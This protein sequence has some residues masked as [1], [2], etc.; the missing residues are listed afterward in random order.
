MNKTKKTIMKGAVI[1]GIIILP[2]IYSITYLKG[3]WDPYNNLGDMKV[4]IVNN[5]KCDSNCKSDILIDKLKDSDSFNFIVKDSK[6]AEEGLHDK[7]YYAVITIPSDFTSSFENADK[8]DRSSATITYRPNNKTNYIASQL[9]NNALLQVEMKLDSEVSKEVVGGLSTK[10]EEIPSLTDRLS[11]GFSNLANGTSLLDNGVS[12]L[13]EG[14]S[15]LN[16]NY[17][18]FDNG[19]NDLNNVIKESTDGINTINDKSGQIREGINT[20]SQ[21]MNTLREGTEELSNNYQHIAY[22]NIAVYSDSIDDVGIKK[23]YEY[24]L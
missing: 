16:S 24:K 12:T 21:S 3:F 2:L 17:R 22:D 7:K 5:D 8:K 20:I 6:T 4:A 11:N 10:L 13:K 15:T 18:A 1:F 19:V 23:I 9:I 14:T